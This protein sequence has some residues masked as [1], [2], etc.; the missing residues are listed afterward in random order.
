[1]KGYPCMRKK[2]LLNDGWDFSIDNDGKSIKVD[3]PHSWNGKDGQDGGN[4]YKR[5]QAKYSRTFL[6]PALAY[7]EMLLLV[8]EGANSVCDVFLNGEKILH[9]EGGY[10]RF[11]AE[12]MPS[13]LKDENLLEVLVDN[14]AY[15]TIYPDAADFTF[16][17]GL[18]RDVYLVTLNT[19]HFVS[20]EYSS[21]SLKCTPRVEGNKGI[22]KVDVKANSDDIIKLFLLDDKGNE[23]LS[24]R[25][26]EEAVL[27][28]PHL[29]NGLKDPY[30]YTVRALLVDKETSSVLD[31]VFEK[32]GFRSFFIDP[33]KGFFLN[34]KKYP[35][36][37]VARH[38]D[39]PSIGNAI[40]K[41]EMDEDMDLIREIGATTI[42]L[43]HYQHDQYFYDLCDKYG[44]IVW[45]EIPY[46]SKHFVKGYENAK[47]QLGELIHQNYN[48]PSII[49]WGISN[50][51]TMFRKS[52]GKD[53]RDVHHKLNDF[54]HKEDP[55]RKT[56][57]ACFSMMTIFNRIAHIT[58]L[59]SYN[60]YWGWYAPFTPVTCWVLDAWHLFY[61]NS[62]IGL[63][64]YGAEG[65]P[66]LHNSHP[67]RFDN[68]EEYQAKYHEKMLK[69]FE[70]RDYIWATH[71]WNMFDF[72][73]DGR[74]QGGEKGINHK[75]LVT[76]DR[77]IKK[78]A[79][80]IYKAYWS[81]EPF[82]H[83]CSKRYINRT[84]KYATIKVYSNQNEVTFYNNG[85]KINTVKGDKIFKLKI[86]LEKAN[87][88]EVVSGDLK[89][90]CVIKQVDKKD[91]SYILPKGGSNLSWQK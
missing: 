42:R 5:T 54:A 69:D 4:D 18:Y 67:R 11:F 89:D 30:L 74:N 35:L 29:W 7:D 71:V 59:C 72:G 50:E 58:D 43:S 66:N 13:K 77:K 55:T 57:I 48:H 62:P 51:I 83:V 19:R 21:P 25:P 26:G 80:Y 28:N 38:Q 17:G 91:P 84:D 6:K 24:F 47:S 23:V 64:E 70:K 2:I 53:C 90:S 36:R 41:K 76:F 44:L 22:L 52:F 39:R 65:M 3:I 60:L 61:P 27:E 86:R 45:A 46:I 33:K 49:C 9:H 15:D 40:T 63:S 37:G 56:T 16:Y 85:K 14:R 81:K 68:T 82:V 31:E 12:I 8:F 79:F 88:I 20:H 34:G 1:M 75:G 78:D 73:S 87:N 32:I 10:S